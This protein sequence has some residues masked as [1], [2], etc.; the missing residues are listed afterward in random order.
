[1]KPLMKYAGGKSREIS[2]IQPLL[3]RYDRYIEP[4]FGGGA[5]F[6]HLSPESAVINDISKP[7]IQFYSLVKA[8]DKE[9]QE[10]L[11]NYKNSF[12][13]LV[14]YAQ[15][16]S[17]DFLTIFHE[18]QSKQIE[19]EK[20]RVLLSAYVSDLAWRVLSVFEKDFI[21]LPDFYSN[22][23][24]SAEDKFLRTIKNCEKKVFTDEALCNN[25]VTGFVNGFYIYFRKVYNDIN[26]NR[27]CCPSL[28][29]QA[30]NFFF[31]R[32]YCYGSLFRYNA[33]NEFNVP[34]G[35]MSYNK[36]S[37]KTKIDNMFCRETALLF[38]NTDIYCLDFEDFFKKINLTSNDFMFLDPPYDTAFSDY[39][40][41]SFSK[42]DH[43]RLAYS[44]KNVPSK[45][46]LVIKNTD[47]INSLYQK[48]FNV[49]HF[50]KQYSCNIKN[51]NCRD[52]EHLIISNF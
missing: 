44:L 15:S 26:L 19:K 18:Y 39:D 16:Y 32:E 27:T 24:E 47:F 21:S 1:M 13:T 5:L 8:Q 34:Y 25:L 49:S 29:Y 51:R 37:L 28:A 43:E 42:Q 2:K 6:F 52:A 36:K 30:A 50:D 41:N 31:I 48:D 12:D 22:L 40:G 10:Y 38:S 7:L 11:L 17:S 9:F 35:G 45:F 4:F 46:L 3:P 33:N 23:L 14:F 20:L